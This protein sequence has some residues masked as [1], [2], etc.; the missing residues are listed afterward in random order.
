MDFK[1]GGVDVLRLNTVLSAVNGIDFT[2][3]ATGNAPFFSAVGTDTNVDIDL[4]PKG[5]GGARFL[6]KN[7]NEVLVGADGTASAVNELTVTNAATANAPK[8]SAT[9]G[10]TDIGMNIQT[11]GA[12]VHQLLD[13]NGNEVLKTA[14]GVASAVNEVTITN[15]ATGNSPRIAATGDDAVVDLEITGKAGGGRVIIGDSGATTQEIAIFDD[16]V[17]AVNEV[18]ITN[19]ATGVGPSIAATGVNTNIDLNLVPKGSGQ[20]DIGSGGA[21]QA[22]MEAATATDKIVTPANL[23]DAMTLGTEQATT[24][25]TEFDF[26]IR[27]GAKRV[28]VFINQASLTSTALIGAQLGDAGGIEATGY[29]G[30]T[31]VNGVGH[32]AWSTFAPISRIS[33]AANTWITKM[34]WTLGDDNNTWFTCGVSSLSGGAVDTHQYVGLKSLSGELTTLRVMGGTFDAGAV[35]VLEE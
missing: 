35:N 7:G 34:V 17:S 18:T 32:T 2:A 31:S 1:L 15:A 22:E 30:T 16:V 20:I 11:K 14:A 24:S 26:T 25:G 5:T 6:D 8:L 27:A 13:G 10:D 19:A 4:K 29:V 28:S 12:G 9:G 23:A 21:T 3:A 33:A